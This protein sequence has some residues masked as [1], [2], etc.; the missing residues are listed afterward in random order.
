MRPELGLIVREPYATYIVSGEK[1]WEIRRYPTHIR[2]RIGIVS[3]RGWIG[4]VVLTEVRGPVS[5]EVLRRQIARHRAD[6]A[7]LEAYARGRPLY[8]WVF[9]DPQQFPKPIPIRR[10]RGPMVWIRLEEALEERRP[11]RRR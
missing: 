6:S 2:G 11:S 10:P 9:T 5:L 3:P 1:T 8:I 7:F 4:T